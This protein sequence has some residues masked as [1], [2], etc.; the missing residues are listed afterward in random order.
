MAR[1]TQRQGF[2]LGSTI[3]QGIQMLSGKNV[4][5]YTLVFLD[6]TIDQPRNGEQTM[7]NPFVSIGRAKNCTIRYSDEFP[8]VS[9]QHAYIKSQGG[10]YFLEPDPNATNPTLLNNEPVKGTRELFAGDEIRLSYEGPRLRFLH[11]PANKTTASMKFTGRLKEFGSQAL[12]PYKRAVYILSFILMAVVGFTCWSFIYFSNKDSLNQEQVADLKKSNEIKDKKIEN[13]D[14]EIESTKITM[15]EVLKGRRLGT[16][17]PVVPPP[18]DAVTS[19][20]VPS[21]RELEGSIYFIYITNV[22]VGQDNISKPF[23][24]DKDLSY[25]WS[26][27]GFLLED[28]RFVTARHVIQPW[29]FKIDC[30]GMESDDLD[31]QVKTYLNNVEITGGK[32]EITYLAI[33]PNGDRFSFTNSD[34]VHDLSKDVLECGGKDNPEYGVKKCIKYSTDWAYI[35][36][37]KRKGKLKINTELAENLPKGM[38]VYGLGYSYG[39]YL[40]SNYKLEPLLIEGKVVQSKTTNG[41]IS[42]AANALDAG[43]SG[44][45]VMIKM[46]DGSFEVVG[47]ISNR[48]GQVQFLV[49]ISEIW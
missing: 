35:K 16:I 47:I 40:Q 34:V 2:G 4:D 42:I 18:S 49:P 23:E 28:G 9:R 22:Q 30:G 24:L 21:L 43:S 13:L 41:L 6:P 46:A 32:V 29:R 33:S 36:F 27:T 3:R 10:R 17:K 38:E 7:W 45:P 8:T 12:R 25:S 39:S 14:K 44:G 26:G 15:S 19:S 31:Q 20:S 37:N 5:N 48:L 1:P 11:T